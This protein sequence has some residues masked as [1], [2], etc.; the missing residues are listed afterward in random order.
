MK[1]LATEGFFAFNDKLY[2]QIDGVAMG[3]PL[4]PTLANFFLGNLEN[5]VFEHSLPSH[6]KLY[7]RYVDDVFAVF[8]DNPA[9]DYFLNVLN[10]LHNNIKFTVEKSTVS[11]M[12]SLD[13]DVKVNND[14]SFE[15]CVWRK[16]THTGLFLNFNAACPVKWKS[17]L[18]LCM[19]HRA[20]SICSSKNIFFSEV[21]KLKSF[22]LC[23]NYPATL[24]DNVF[25]HFLNADT[26]V[27]E[28]LDEDKRTICFFRVPYIDKESRRFVT[29]LQVNCV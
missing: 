2:K 5:L 15:T 7:F 20:K 14:G 8:N 12:Q 27:K 25:K 13:V 11:Y 23:N 22:F 24:F 9:V 17:G 21:N 3:S 16:P 26:D 18:N 4:G 29:S 19:L 10:N 1:H 28:K 6:P